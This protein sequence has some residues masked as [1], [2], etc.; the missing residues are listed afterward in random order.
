MRCLF[1]PALPNCHLHFLTFGQKAVFMS[2][3]LVCLSGV[4]AAATPTI[5]VGEWFFL[6]GPAIVSIPINVTGGDSITGGSFIFEISQGGIF[7]EF[8]SPH[9]QSI[10]MTTGTIFSG[11]PT[12]S[13]QTSFS[14]RNSNTHVVLGG[15]A[16]G[17]TYTP[18]AGPPVKTKET[19]L[20]PDGGSVAA[21]GLLGTLNISLVGANSGIFELRITNMLTGAGGGSTTSFTPA[22]VGGA[23]TNGRITWIGYI[24][25]EPS[26]LVL[27][28]FAAAGLSVVAIRKHLLIAERRNESSE[29]RVN[30]V[31]HTVC[32]H[33]PNDP[34]LH[35]DLR[36]SH[37]TSCTQ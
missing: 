32:E 14:T 12:S 17:P 30:V 18:T 1:R 13:I 26:T 8:G 20:I 23:F 25:P 21:N 5:V 9:F 2:V 35:A 4:D 37:Q 3:I 10:D 24:T 27:G 11:V 19:I 31:G 28:L 34:E 22:G 29:C 36:A 6:D 33:V 7:P 16:G 15:A